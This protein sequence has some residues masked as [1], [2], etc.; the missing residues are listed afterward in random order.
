M[1]IEGLDRSLKT[2]EC[3]P[4]PPATPPFGPP[5]TTRVPKQ[6]VVPLAQSN[7]V[8]GCCDDSS[9]RECRGPTTAV[10]GVG[11]YFPHPLPRRLTTLL[12]NVTLAMAQTSPSTCHSDRIEQD[13]DIEGP[14]GTLAMPPRSSV[15]CP[16]STPPVP[17]HKSRSPA[18]LGNP[19]YAGLLWSTTSLSS[20]S[21][22]WSRAIPK[23][24]LTHSTLFAT[25]W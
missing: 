1:D 22:R 12:S 9:S 21:A 4:G 14:H 10:G 17:E 7:A 13:G 23:A 16:S 18:S 5:P 11:S 25:V 24:F 2:E 20:G 8:T 15:A 19:T 6:K 3:P